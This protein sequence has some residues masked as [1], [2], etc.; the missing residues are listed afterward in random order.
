MFQ[1]QPMGQLP[2]ARLIAGEPT[3]STGKN[4]SS[5]VSA[6][7]APHRGNKCRIAEPLSSPGHCYLVAVWV[8]GRKLP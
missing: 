4:A 8:D 3:P 7:M 5:R 6:A 2:S 1:T